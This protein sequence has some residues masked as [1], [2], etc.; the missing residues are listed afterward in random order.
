MSSRRLV[1]CCSLALSLCIPAIARPVAAANPAPSAGHSQGIAEDCSS[2]HTVFDGQPA[3][4]R[5]EEKSLPLSQTPRLSVHSAPNDGVQVQGWDKDSYS[6]TACKMAEGPESKAEE[7][8]AQIHVSIADGQVSASGPR[9]SGRWSVHFLIR[10]PKGANVSLEATNGPLS[11]YDLNGT[12]RARASNGPISIKN[13]NGDADL[14]ASNGPISVSGSSG[15]IRLRTQNGPIS[16]DVDDSS[17]KGQGLTADAQNGPVSL[18]VPSGFQSGF[19]VESRGSGRVSCSSSVCNDARKT[20]DED[21][22]RIE[23]GATPALIHL[24]TYNG[25]ASVH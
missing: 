16:V 4:V 6:I 8:L 24:S 10:A 25:P 19:V 23:Y 20:W 21:R 7:I 18:R 14:E 3:I 1:S 13:L 11:I 5:S 17:W 9:D 22:R 2:L 12:L 15:N